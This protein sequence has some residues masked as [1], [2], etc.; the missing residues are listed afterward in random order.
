MSDSFLEVKRQTLEGRRAQLLEEF[1]AANQQLMSTLDA[2]NQIRINRNIYLLEKKIGAVEKEIQQL[3]SEQGT[4]PPASPEKSLADVL[5]IT[6]GRGGGFFS[7]LPGKWIRLKIESNETVQDCEGQIYD[8]QTLASP[9]G[10]QG[11]P[12][13]QSQTTILSWDDGEFAPI[14]LTAHKPRYLQLAWRAESNSLMPADELRIASARDA[15]KRDTE[16]PE[17]G[18]RQD[19]IPLE[20]GYYLLIVRILAKGYTTPLECRYRLYWP[21]EGGGAKLSELGVGLVEIGESTS[22]D[23]QA[24]ANDSDDP[25]RRLIGWLKERCLWTDYV[26][27]IVACV[28]FLAT[29]AEAFDA[30]PC[31]L[32]LSFAILA[33][34]GGAGILGFS[35]LHNYRSR[36]RTWDRLLT[37][38]LLILA[39]GAGV[40]GYVDRDCAPVSGFELPVSHF[41][42]QVRVEVEGTGEAIV[43]A[44]VMI[45]LESQAPRNEF[46]DSHGIA[47]VMLDASQ[48][49]K[50]ARLIVEAPG[51]TRHIESIDLTPGLSH[52]VKLE[53]ASTP[54]MTP[55]A[56]K[57]STP[58]PAVT[59]TPTTTS[60]EP[61]Q[62]SKPLVCDPPHPPIDGS[63]PAGEV[64]ITSPQGDC[65]AVGKR[66]TIEVTWGGV[67]TTGPVTMWMLIYSPVI[68]RYYPHTCTQVLQASGSQSCP[69][70]FGSREPYEVVAVLADQDADAV[71]QQFA[72]QGTGI[73]Q[74][75]LPEGLAEKDSLSVVCTE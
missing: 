36:Y 69:V 71:L 20:P 42:Y 26:A 61:T 34:V 60:L 33:F 21:G 46:T 57:A 29:I 59:P 9:G 39:T 19:F 18:V 43:D 62:C 53:P 52:V 48:K 10:Q 13:P 15:G 37:L 2:T 4:V 74:P 32:L 12:L 35:L 67:S 14:L 45:E 7:D 24:A 31:P 44:E 66:E 5:K 11:A 65:V 25:L 54:A 22:T 41:E 51:Y 6:M 40:W 23:P 27:W 70:Y 75:D 73:V 49:D 58:S 68:E 63:G 72:K 1:E 3:L 28:A 30:S 38:V 16:A 64:E 47:R 17:W 55:Q 50:P 56:S 8:V